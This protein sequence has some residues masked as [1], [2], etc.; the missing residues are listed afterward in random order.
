MSAEHEVEQGFFYR[1][2]NKT[3]PEKIFNFYTR[4]KLKLHAKKSS[5][6]PE[7]KIV[8]EKKSKITNE[9]KIIC[10]EKNQNFPLSYISAQEKQN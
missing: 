3:P 6:L 1:K 7:K 10:R 9:K 5:K 8:P 2:K 4:E